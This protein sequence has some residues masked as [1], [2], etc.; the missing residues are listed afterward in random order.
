MRIANDAASDLD[1]N[2]E[3]KRCAGS[4]PGTVHSLPHEVLLVIF[5]K[6][7]L[8]ERCRMAG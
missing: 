4:G 3:V 1:E 8:V 2:G 6:M 7:T 5:N